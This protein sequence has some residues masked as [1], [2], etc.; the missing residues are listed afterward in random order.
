MTAQSA[1]SDQDKRAGRKRTLV[2]SVIIFLLIPLTIWVGIRFLGDR[3]YLFISLLIILFT[4]IP[5]II[6]FEG[7]RPEAREIV[8]IA[9]MAAIAACGNLAF[10]MFGPF[11][12]GTAL[13]I[14]AGICLGPEEG[15]LT[16]AMA[17]LVVNMFV[18]QGPW[19]P[20]QM[21]CWGLLG[22]LGGLCFNRDLEFSKKEVNFK[23]VMGPLICIVI[24]LAAGFGI[25]LFMGGEGTFMGWRLYVFG[26]I[27]LLA[28]VL[29]QRKRLPADRVTLSV[30]GFL[31]TFII[32]GGIMNIAALVMSSAIPASDVGVDWGSL[33]VLY[34]SGAPYDA[35]HALGS[36]FFGALLGPVM[37][38]KLERVKI[39]F[40]LYY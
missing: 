24:A 27:G 5:L 22:F 6:R 15:F 14:I 19:T 1:Q 12:A 30:F 32:Y 38:E 36:A 33:K 8:V 39:K 17:R 4:S 34:I 23:V 40:G 7:R 11:Q 18:S 37:I 31:S 3:K 28:G 35:V 25:W 20:W 13:V 10:Y 29:L 16:G 9:V 2:A 26:A 21:F